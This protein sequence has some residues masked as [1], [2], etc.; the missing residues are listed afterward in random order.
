MEDELSV[1]YRKPEHLELQF[2]SDFREK[3]AINL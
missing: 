1:L 3:H 2:T